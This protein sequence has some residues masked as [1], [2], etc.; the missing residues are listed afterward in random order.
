MI[1]IAVVIIIAF[2]FFGG[3]TNPDKSR[4]HG[5][6]DT[7]F[8]VY[9]QDYTFAEYGRLQRFYQLS[10]ALQLGFGNGAWADVLGRI[11]QRFE[12]G[13]RVPVDFAFNLIVLRKELEKNGIRASDEEV[14]QAFRKLPALQ[15]D[16]KFD[17]AMGEM[18]INELGSMGFRDVDL[19]DLL[20]DW[21]G[22]QKLQKAVS[23]N[24]ITLD[25]V[26]KQFYASS[27]QTIKA[28]SIP[29]S[30]ETY[31]KTAE[32]KE[33]EIKKYY[34]EQKENFLSEEKR[35]VSYV[36]FAKPDVEKLNAEDTVKAR[37][38]YGEK[39][40]QFA[41]AVTVAGA[42]FEDEAKKA[43]I[44]IKTEPAFPRSAPP[45][46]L[47]EEYAVVESAFQN[48]PKL[49]AVT[50]AI[51]GSKGYYVV[52]VTEIVE[53]KQQELAAVQESIKTML[54]G[55]KAQE[56]MTKAANDTRKTL[57][58]AVK[59]GKKFE[60]AAKE[61][62]VTPEIMADF[63]PSSPPDLS[64]GREIAL[65]A[66]TTAP[67]GFTKP[68]TTDSGIMLVYVTAKELRKREDGDKMK[69]NVS[70]YLS[71]VAQL[72]VFRS[73]FERRRDE[74]KVDAVPIIQ[75]TMAGS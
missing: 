38:S 17:G 52:K 16:G 13:E 49:H 40:N 41:T 74:A 53:P 56:A 9:G 75:R 37:N 69:E 24:Y 23:A 26:S 73:W 18:I 67:G 45:E 10:S 66:R 20:R 47:K 51:E 21:L 55:Q 39:V 70:S 42:S 32:V 60:E 31:K 4:Q 12:S 59:A 35:A 46:A 5:P 2:T 65:E 68:L 7:A 43:G 22:F 63:S 72:D 48:D 28:A 57:E 34:D 58:D 30:L 19:Y 15:K 33:D 25:D 14:K 36:L 62:G 29:F 27:F 61:A 11:A 71:N 6:A 54:I 3:Y 50:D 1:I 64:N 44:E 8:T